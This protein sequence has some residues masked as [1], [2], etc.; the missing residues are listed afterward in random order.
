MAVAGIPND[1]GDGGGVTA[2][3]GA[4]RPG[5]DRSNGV[6]WHGAGGDDRGDSRP[7]PGE[8]AESPWDPDNPD[9]V[10][11]AADRSACDDTDL[12]TPRPYNR[13]RP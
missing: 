3:R 7:R 11:A 8:F 6:R 1:C 12:A 5:T 9:D 10:G 13:P 4:P 2:S